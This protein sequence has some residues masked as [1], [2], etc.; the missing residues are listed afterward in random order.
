MVGSD[1]SPEELQAEIRTLRARVAE[2]ELAEAERK[3]AGEAPRESLGE[4]ASESTSLANEEIHLSGIDIAWDVEAG[5]CTFE[6]LPVAMMWID[7]TLAGVMS[8][9]QSMVG[10][11]R[12]GLALQSEG[13]KS[14]EADWQ[15]IS[16][17]ADFREG[18]EAIANIAAVAGWGEWKLVSLRKRKR[19]CRFRV[20]N[21][22]EG[23]YQQALGVCWGSGMLAGKLAGY[24]SRLFETNCWAEQTA[25]VARGDKFDE[26]V[27]GPSERS[28]ENEIENLLASDEATRADMAVALKKLRAE[29]AERQRAQEQLEQSEDR[30]RN[31]VELAPDGIVTADLKGV[32]TSCNTAFIEM[33]G[34]SEDEIVGRHFTELPTLFERDLPTYVRMVQAV[35][36]GK[37]RYLEFQ[38]RHKD[39]SLHW[40]EAHASLM[41]EGRKVVGLQA[42]VRDT[43]ERKQAEEALRESEKKFRSVVD[44]IGVGIIVIQDGQDVYFNSRLHEYLGY[45]EQEFRE[46]DFAALVH[47]DDRPLALNRIRQRLAGELTD[48]A[49]AEMR[50]LA[51]S[52][53]VKW[54]ET[55]SVVIQWEGR[56]AVQAFVHDITERKQAEQALRRSEEQYRTLFE[57]THAAVLVTGPDGRVV[58]A[59]PAVAKLLG[60]Q[61]PTEMIGTQV[62][63]YYA[64][65][66][67]GGTILAEL[68]EK[69]SVEERETA[70]KRRD[71]SV[72]H[73]VGSANVVKDETGNVLRIEGVFSDITERKQAEEALRESEERYRSLFEDVPI[74]LYQTTPAGQIM[75][76]NAA[77]VEML[78]YPDREALQAAGATA[79][80]LDP[81]DRRQWQN[82]MQREGTVRD[83]EV[84]IRRHDG[85]T[86]CVQENARTIR[87]ETGRVLYYQGSQED[88]TE[89]KRAEEELRESEEKYRDLVE[90]T[91]DVVFSLDE[92]GVMTYI[93]PVVETVIG[94][95]PSEI[96][97]RPFTDFVHREDLQRIRESYQQIL[98]GHSSEANEYRILT[99]TGGFRWLRASSRLI[100][101][102][103][104]V[105]GVQ[106]VLADITER[107]QAEEALRESERRFRG[108]VDNALIG[109]YRTN[110][111]G[112]VLY[113]N[114]ALSRMQGFASPEEVLQES[115]L[116]RYKN[117]ADRDRLLGLLRENGEVREF[118]VE[119]LGKQGNTIS[120]LLSATLEGDVISGTMM[121]IT[122]RKRAEEALRESEQKYRTL[123][124]NMTAGFA[125]HEM[126]YDEQG[127]PADYRY[128]EI[129]PAFEKLTGIPVSTLLGKTVKEVLPNTEQYWIDVSGKV[130]QT[131]EPTAYQNYSRE[132]GRHYDT[133]LF[134]T[135]KDQFAVVFTDVTERVQAEEAIERRSRELAALNDIAAVVSQS[136]DLDEILNAALDKVLEL[137]Q[138]DA[139]GIYLV[140]VERIN[141][142]L[143]TRRGVSERYAE[144]MGS[145]SLDERTVEAARAQ[146]KLGRLILSLEAVLPNP[147]ELRRARSAMEREGLHPDTVVPVLLQAK[148]EI[149]GL[150]TVTSREPRRYTEAE[151]LL[152]TSIAQQLAVAIHN[153][154]LHQSTRRRAA[155]LELIWR[156]SQRTTAIRELDELLRQAANLIGEAFDYHSTQ[157]LL[158]DGDYVVLAAS[159][160]PVLRPLEEQ[161]RFRIGA[162]GI[163]GWVAGSG[164]PLLVP[165]VAQ[166]PRYHQTEEEVGTRSELA[167]PIVLKDIVIG[168]LDVQS[169]EPNAFSKTDIPTLQTIAD[170]LAITIENA[171]LYQELEAYSGFLEQAVAERT[172]DLLQEKERVEA[173]LRSTG[174]AMIITDIE[175]R[176]LSVNPAFEAQ[177][178][179]SADEVASMGHVRMLG[180]W[181]PDH[182]LVEGTMEALRQGHQWQGDLLLRRKDGSEY[183]AEVSISPLHVPG[184][185]GEAQHSGYVGAIRDISARKEIERMK[186]AFVSN[187]THELRTPITTLKMHHGLLKMDPGALGMSLPVLQRETERLNNTVEDLLRL[188]RL[189]QGRVTLDLA[190]VDL[191]AL[192]SQ[193]VADRQPLAE[194]KG[195]ALTFAGQKD[196]PGV[197]ADAGLLSQVLSILLTNALNY[198]ASGGSVAISTEAREA[199]GRRWA[200]F[201]VSDTGPGI[202]P[203]EQRQVFE[204][205]VRG[206]V[207]RESGVPGTGLGLALAWE[208]VERHRGRIELA[209]EGIP[210]KGAT[211]TVWLPLSKP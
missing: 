136:L 118:E 152:L 119:L 106:G 44:N 139:G 92:E 133:W 69:G 173:I 60:Y 150:M 158:V 75:D 193:H 10:T 43:T 156:V 182:E 108:L 72:V 30:Y 138:V 166:E 3:R 45:T 180:S 37:T 177:T 148:D 121:D 67:E 53:E 164:E 21:S 64:D 86:I 58:S 68:I 56:P 198:T 194:G 59:N 160:D 52:D 81:E 162:E 184:E 134:S 22:W 66:A 96:V 93:S 126:I 76:A 143:V 135:A 151:L 122:E 62:S 117:L 8:G 132:L 129:N 159:T 82:I 35:L 172:A 185:E 54:I 40:G 201:S 19:T 6:T 123:F 137:M 175:G 99:Q 167:L 110:L 203:E 114:E 103:D 170:Q 192:A 174:D 80:Y 178:G 48:S 120:I 142:D 91:N 183:D 207:G 169:S 147:A 211:F 15:V 112:D 131:G 111:K 34:F 39:G 88:I 42:I 97:G 41:T 199:D 191:N 79:L 154:Q 95:S 7:S 116:A 29:I 87:D 181:A 17:H 205:F 115:V 189:D 2:L 5:T 197:Q 25:F 187:V 24:C 9:V 101:V 208:I 176:I 140:D 206:K 144:E 23:R 145:V 171:K 47:P 16:Q 63:E 71:G 73:T 46:I 51:K 146:S 124:E 102:E 70:L 100:F 38:W 125:L 36:G 200:A 32:L 74:G 195:L 18:F 141:I 149:L 104:R 113:V 127:Q 1:R 163:T 130:A 168:V 33:T 179:Y 155:R 196:L 50:V 109:V 65:P 107:V 20:R 84:Q 77:W 83:F 57:Y 61:S 186:D 209:S 188:S 105:V 14:V 11:E 13:R 204:R 202:P 153:A 210:G 90:N 28:I 190:T 31:I 89:R 157:V 12:F 161:L 4:P 26:F 27:V 55:G 165:D 98:S 94:H 85:E 78:G 128:L 49:P